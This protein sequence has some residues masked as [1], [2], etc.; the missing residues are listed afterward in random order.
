MMTFAPPAIPIDAPQWFK[1][2]A[3]ALHSNINKAAA[4]SNDYLGG[5]Y[6]SSAPGRPQDGAI[7]LADG[8]NWNPGSGKGAYRYD[9]SAA[10]YNFLG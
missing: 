4:G 10:T 7:Y 2:Y 8:T 1:D 5:R 9:A 3:R 6:L